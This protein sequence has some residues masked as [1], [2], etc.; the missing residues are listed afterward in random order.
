MGGAFAWEKMGGDAS[1]ATGSGHIRNL[2]EG[3]QT[4]AKGG[5]VPPKD[6]SQLGKKED[7]QQVNFLPDDGRSDATIDKRGWRARIWK[8]EER[9][10][11]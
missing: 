3:C 10:G 2:E 4:S 9:Q 1:W 5:I 11:N 6:G 8:K 7:M